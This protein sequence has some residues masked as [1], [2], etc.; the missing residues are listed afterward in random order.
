MHN[1][2]TTIGVRG[3]AATTEQKHDVGKYFY[4]CIDKQISGTKEIFENQYND[5]GDITNKSN[6]AQIKDQSELVVKWREQTCL[7]S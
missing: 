7:Q 2:S 6:L 4:L 1:T 5:E 3:T